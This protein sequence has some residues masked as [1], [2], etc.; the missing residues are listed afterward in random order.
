VRN[1]DKSNRGFL[2]NDKVYALMQEQLS[3]QRSM[4][5]MKRII[6]GLLAFVVV[7]ALANLGTSFA[8]AIL[9]KD[10]TTSNGQLVDKKTNEAVATAAAVETY[11]V[12]ADDADNAR[13]L[14]ECSSN[15]GADCEATVT[16]A[17]TMSFA[18]ARALLLNCK[19]N[20]NVQLQL[21]SG[22][23]VTTKT[24]CG[25]LSYCSGSSY[26][27]VQ[28]TPT[29][30]ELCIPG[31]TEKLGVKQVDSATY[32]LSRDLFAPVSTS[33]LKT[34]ECFSDADCGAGTCS[35]PVYSTVM[36]FPC[37][38]DSDCGSTLLCYEGSCGP[39]NS[40]SCGVGETCGVPACG[41]GR[42]C[43]I[44]EDKCKGTCVY[45]MT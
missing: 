12:E 11:T 22:D 2:T 43:H 45:S 44:K 28:G 19:K 6:F 32:A 29:A 1:L 20:K 42:I 7:L 24:V 9:A 25:G 39:C 5:Q 31:T 27:I 35:F 13:K 4:F 8:S 33:T 3:M 37:S 26:T 21:I 23:T 38:S 10:T 15:K 17:T 14:A 30:G 36:P 41:G 34:G 40:T 16:T 18:S